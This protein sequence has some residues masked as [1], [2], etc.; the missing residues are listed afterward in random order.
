MKVTVFYEKNDKPHRK[1]INYPDSSWL[2]VFDFERIQNRI[3][4][5]CTWG[6]TIVMRKVC[7]GNEEYVGCW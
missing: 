3:H 6:D 2:S 4:R 1:T 7:V 5:D